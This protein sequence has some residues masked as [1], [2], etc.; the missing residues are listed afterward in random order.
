MVEYKY[1]NKQIKEVNN[2][3]SNHMKQHSNIKHKGIKRIINNI[4]IETTS[5]LIDL[6]Y[7]DRVGKD[8]GLNHVDNIKN[9][10]ENIIATQQPT[11]IKDLDINGNDLIDLGFKG[12]NIGRM[13]NMLLD[14]VMEDPNQNNKQR[15]IKKAKQ[16]I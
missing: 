5:K 9:I 4:G 13:L 8:E 15:L 14:I 6:F 11:K 1:T 2:I 12:K 3:I 16:L 10:F 7:A